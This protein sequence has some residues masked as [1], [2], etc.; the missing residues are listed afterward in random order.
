MG[1]VVV[2]GYG[3]TYTYTYT[4]HHVIYISPLLYFLFLLLYVRAFGPW[5]KHMSHILQL[6]GSGEFSIIQVS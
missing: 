4:M 5:E 2:Y 3:F 6:M 1:S